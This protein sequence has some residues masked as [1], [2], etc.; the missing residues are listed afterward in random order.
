MEVVL[1]AL[2]EHGRLAPYQIAEA[3]GLKQTVVDA[4]L[5]SLLLRRLVRCGSHKTPGRGG[6]TAR[7]IGEAMDPLWSAEDDGP[8]N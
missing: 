5:Q 7:L 1:A 2:R 8:S 3:T 6:Q 4:A